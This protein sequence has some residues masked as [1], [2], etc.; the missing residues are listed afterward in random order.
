VTVPGVAVEFGVKGQGRFQFEAPYRGSR[1]WLLVRRILE[2]GGRGVV[3]PG[4]H[5]RIDHLGG[6]HGLR[7]RLGL[8]RFVRA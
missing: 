1:Q 3:G 8:R 2:G 5:G 7:P 4:C 6:F